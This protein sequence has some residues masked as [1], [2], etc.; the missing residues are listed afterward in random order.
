MEN[1]QEQKRAFVARGYLLWSFEIGGNFLA[2]NK[3]WLLAV[4][5]MEVADLT[6]LGT[7]Q[8]ISMSNVSFSSISC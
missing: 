8:L 2:G 4:G 6:G 1:R 3:Q 5:F 7:H